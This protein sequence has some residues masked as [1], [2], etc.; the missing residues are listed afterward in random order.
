LHWVFFKEGIMRI[1]KSQHFLPVLFLMGLLVSLSSCG[2]A[3]SSPE[4]PLASKPDRVQIE[5]NRHLPSGEKPVLTLTVGSQIESLYTTIYALPQMPEQA[6]CTAELGPHY[7]LTFYQGQKLLVTVLAEKHG[8]RRV[9][10]SGEQHDRTA[11]GKETFWDQLDSAIYEATPAASVD[12]LSLMPTSSNTGSPQMGQI[13]SA[14]VAQDF[15]NAILA[16]PL[17]TK[18]Y[19]DSPLKNANIVYRTSDC[20]LIFH[21]ADQSIAAA[22][23]LKQNQIA[24]DGENH[25]RGG[26]YRMNEQFTQLFEQILAGTTF[27]AANP[28]QLSVSISQ[29]SGA[30][31]PI[32]VHDIALVQKLYARVLM[33]PVA[34]PPSGNCPGNDKEA[35]K[36]KWYNLTFSQWDLVLLQV[37][38]YEGSCTFVTE[39]AERGQSQYLQADQEFWTWLHQ[40]ASL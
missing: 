35:G 6:V 39:E 38:A 16:L 1:T 17:I 10:L 13:T 3:L 23:D 24:L 29:A 22:I 4:K 26:V 28:D 32:R 15:Y 34:Q 19:S 25:S 40:A 31:T 27:V 37:T 30:P 8:C 21:S 36:A 12:R 18:N 33:L 5:I 14:D 11:G 9:S 20:L 2:P 7:T